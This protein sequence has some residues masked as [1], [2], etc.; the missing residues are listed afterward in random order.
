M[1]SAPSPLAQ[2][3]LFALRAL[4]GH[5]PQCGEGALFAGYARLHPVCPAC[6]LVYRRESG[7]MTGSMYLSA[8]VT[9]IFAALL[10]V[11]LFFATDWSTPVALSVGVALVL[12]FSYF[13][14]PRAIG[15]WVAT[16]YATDVSNGESWTRPRT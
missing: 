11:A 3:K 4:R 2:R 16:E 8:V 14:L 1:S 13:W 15:L 6:G 12:A 9:E 7:A 5:C 10:A